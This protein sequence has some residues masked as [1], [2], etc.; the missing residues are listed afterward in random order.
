MSV[1]NEKKNKLDTLQKELVKQLSNTKA[2]IILLDCEIDAKQKE[3]LALNDE[4]NKL[5]LE[6]NDKKE[7]ALVE[8][9]VSE[10]T[11]NETEPNDLRILL[12]QSEVIDATK[13]ELDFCNRHGINPNKVEP[14]DL[15]LSVN[16]SSCNIGTSCPASSGS[17]S[18]WKDSFSYEI[19]QNWRLPSTEEF[20]ELKEMCN[21]KWISEDSIKGYLIVSPKTGNK[22]FLRASGK[23]D[24]GLYWSNNSAALGKA[25]CL[26]FMQSN[27]LCHNQNS[28]ESKMTI[29]LVKS[30]LS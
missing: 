16:W 30:L 9:I 8:V 18:A 19:I 20:K 10:D 23:S 25:Y 15:G 6:K 24:I 17:Y 3:I 5:D 14:I 22:I 7:S 28:I 12:Q 11:F 27:I 29:R 1:I 26:T 2:D 13:N 4:I 21:W